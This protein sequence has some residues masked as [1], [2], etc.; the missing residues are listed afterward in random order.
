MSF[1]SPVSPSHGRQL[2]KN[3]LSLSVNIC[4]WRFLRS[5]SF[6]QITIILMFVY[7]VSEKSRK[8]QNPGQ[9]T[10]CRSPKIA[11]RS[12]FSE[13]T[14]FSPDPIRRIRVESSKRCTNFQ[15]FFSRWEWK[16]MFFKVSTGSANDFSKIFLGNFGRNALPIWQFGLQIAIAFN[17]AWHCDTWERSWGVIPCCTFSG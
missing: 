5:R 12:P 3:S 4:F 11:A 17:Q 10:T 13:W 16:E 15:L 1:Q 14:W 2:P 8:I 9:P 6:D 7:S